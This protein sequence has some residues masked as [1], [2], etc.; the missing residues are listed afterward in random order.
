MGQLFLF[1]ELCSVEEEYETFHSWVVVIVAQLS[2]YENLK[3]V[4]FKKLVGL[5][6]LFV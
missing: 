2:I 6:I 5:Y 4:Y 1:T 3:I